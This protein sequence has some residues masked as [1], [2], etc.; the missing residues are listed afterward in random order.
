MDQPL[1]AI[2][3]CVDYH[4]LLAITLPHNRHHFES[5]LVVTS[6]ADNAVFEICKENNAEVY[7]TSAFYDD[8]ANF[9]KWKALENGLDHYGRHGWLCLM[10]ADI[11]WPK[12][13]PPTNLQKGCLYTPQRRMFTDLTKPIPYDP[14]EWVKYPIHRNVREWA[15]Y[16]QIFHA[17]D[18]V[19][20]APPWHEINWRH[21]GGADS[22][23]QRLWLDSNKLRPEWD[24]LHLGPAGVNWCGRAT[25]M[26]DGSVNQRQQTNQDCINKLFSERRKNRSTRGSNPYGNEKL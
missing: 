15:G 11:L 14:G 24:C 21:A 3:V 4:D 2:M 25:P 22:Y 9:N 10:D 8:G 13:I 1:R 12:Q 18:P 19:P 7:C 5:V 20:P 26:I 6:P 16:S 23:F 17:D